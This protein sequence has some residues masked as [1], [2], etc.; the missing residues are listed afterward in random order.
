MKT[1]S[2]ARIPSGFNGRSGAL[3]GGA[4]ILLLAVGLGYS[5]GATRNHVMQLTGTASV[6]RTVASIE[7]RGSYYGVSESIA[8]ID[9]TGSFHDDGW[10]ECFG[11]AGSTTTVRFGAVDVALPDDG[12]F[13]QV[14]YV[15]CRSSEL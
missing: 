4:A 5:L 1:E 9:A 8:W 10:P 6:G 2:V 12:G 15:D 3:L 14:V 7:A 13:R 11:G